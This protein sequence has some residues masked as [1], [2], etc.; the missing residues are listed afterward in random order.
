MG[1]TNLEDIVKLPGLFSKLRMQVRHRREQ[2]TV[3]DLCGGHMYRGRD[4]I[5][6]RLA[7]IDVVIR[8]GTG[9]TGDHFVRVHIR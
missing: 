8:M 2:L 7:A 5:V 6:A 9:K 1:T 3:D 4:H